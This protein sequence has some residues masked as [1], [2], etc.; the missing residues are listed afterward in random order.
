MPFGTHRDF[1][2]VWIRKEIWLSK[3]LSL[4]EKALF[5][6]IQSLDNERGCF[7]SNK[8]FAEFLGVSDRQVRTYLNR[9]EEKGYIRITIKNRNQRVIRARGGYRRSSDEGLLDVEPQ[10]DEETKQKIEEAKRE[11]TKRFGSL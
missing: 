3:D 9:L 10:V 2:G 7:A 4:Q 11:I 1:K 6:E 8:H 5:V